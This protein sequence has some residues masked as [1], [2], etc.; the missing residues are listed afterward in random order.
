MYRRYVLSEFIFCQSSSDHPRYAIRKKQPLTELR[1]TVGGSTQFDAPSQAQRPLLVS[2]QRDGHSSEEN[3][4]VKCGRSRSVAIARFDK[5][6]HRQQRQNTEV[7]SKVGENNGSGACTSLANRA[8]A[9]PQCQFKAATT[10]SRRTFPINDLPSEIIDYILILTIPK[11]LTDP[12]PDSGRAFRAFLEETGV[13]DYPRLLNQVCRKWRALV[14]S[15]PII[16]SYVFVYAVNG[17]MYRYLPKYYDKLLALSK[18]QPLTV[19]CV[20]GNMTIADV[21][22]SPTFAPHIHRIRLLSIQVLGDNYTEP[23]FPL[24]EGIATPALEVLR[25]DMKYMDES[26][27]NSGRGGWRGILHSAP[28]LSEFSLAGFCIYWD[29][30]SLSQVGPKAGI[31]WSRLAVLRLPRIPRRACDLLVILSSNLQ[32]QVFQCTVLGHFEDEEQHPS[33]LSE[34]LSGSEDASEDDEE[35]TT[36]R[37]WRGAARGLR[38]ESRQQRKAAYQAM[39]GPHLLLNLS[40][41]DLRVSH[42]P[43]YNSGVDRT[44]TFDERSGLV[45]FIDGL[46]APALTR[47][48]ISSGGGLGASNSSKGSDDENVLLEAQEAGAQPRLLQP[49][50]GDLIERSRCSIR[51]LSLSHLF[52]SLPELLGILELCQHLHSLYLDQPLRFMGSSLLDGLSERSG[53]LLAPELRRLVIEAR[54]VSEYNVFKTTDI[55]SMVNSRWPPGRSDSYIAYVKVYYTPDLKYDSA[56]MLAL[57]RSMRTRRDI[58]VALVVLKHL[59]GGERVKWVTEPAVDF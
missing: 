26:W 57:M 19:V 48:T 16:W 13:R 15:N 37:D 35:G 31:D 21:L 45:K 36:E 56:P 30:F 17:I 47:L 27:E 8:H 29:I 7:Q 20:L 54:A 4:H 32:L 14:G 11:E 1:Y 5:G 34:P 38:R 52:I 22:A 28:R 25:V 18:D 46:D 10:A 2:L 55:L 50:L 41:L 58:R 12:T 40:E 53:R 33:E 23:I 42:D 39:M 59:T 51:H 49:L 6:H 3:S 44:H 24:V 9:Y 43:S